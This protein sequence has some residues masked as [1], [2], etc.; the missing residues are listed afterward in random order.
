MSIFD[1]SFNAQLKLINKASVET[2]RVGKKILKR[3]ISKAILYIEQE[4]KCCFCKT[5]MYCHSNYGNPPKGQIATIE[6]IKP[7]SEGGRNEINNYAL[8][9]YSCNCVRQTVPFDEF[10]RM[11]TCP[12]ER[13]QF[14][15]FRLA[16]IKEEKRRLRFERMKENAETRRQRN[17]KYAEE[18]HKR[19]L[20]NVE[21][22]N[23]RNAE[24]KKYDDWE[25]V[26]GPAF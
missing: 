8:S 14:K 2:S 1:E 15:K 21:K 17:K 11:V 20:K 10:K 4:G 22:K 12:E 18:C 7:K 24:R 25:I 9:C 16:Y 13:G 23:K 6:H 3:A 26:Y 5:Q 19:H